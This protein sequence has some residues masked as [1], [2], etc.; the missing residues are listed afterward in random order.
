[1]TTVAHGNEN[2]LMA[3]TLNPEAAPMFTARD[4]QALRARLHDAVT[5][6]ALGAR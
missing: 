2:G 1:V 5:V 3:P 4:A 6:T